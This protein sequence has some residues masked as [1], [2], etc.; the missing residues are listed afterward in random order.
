MANVDYK[1]KYLEIRNVL[2][3][4]VDQSFK[5]GY[6]Q[7]AQDAQMDAMAQQQQQQAEMMSQMSGGVVDDPDDP[8]GDGQIPMD[9]QGD[10]MMNGAAEA[11][12]EAAGNELEQ[13]MAEL[14][15]ELGKAEKDQNKEHAANLLAN[16]NR[17]M[18]KMKEAQVLKKS[19][20]AIKK[21]KKAN[22]KIQA[23]SIGY[24]HNL[25]TTHKKAVSGQQKIVTD[26]LK[27]WETESTDAA[28][29]ILAVIK[30]EGKA[31]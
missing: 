11:H 25:S 8:N 6:Q 22:K 30:G 12:E 27:K 24:K 21:I 18:K 14:E 13:G 26:I 20:A 5:A 15:A 4:A 17:S 19:A 16:L 23:T 9:D 2:I 29:D 31:D 28:T 7:G 10:Q 3:K 1:K